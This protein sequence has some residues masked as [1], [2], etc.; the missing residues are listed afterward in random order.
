MYIFIIF[1]FKILSMSDQRY[2]RLK[3][4]IETWEKYKGGS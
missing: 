1:T 4:H 2:E 3:L